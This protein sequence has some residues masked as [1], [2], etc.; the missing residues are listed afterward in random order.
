[1]QFEL[2]VAVLTDAYF[3][4]GSGNGALMYSIFGG[5]VKDLRIWLAEG[6][7][8]DGWEPKNREALGHSI[9]VSSLLFPERSGHALILSAHSKRKSPHSLLSSTSMRSRSSGLGM[10]LTSGSMKRKLYMLCAVL[11]SSRGCPSCIYNSTQS[12]CA[13]RGMLPDWL[14][15]FGNQRSFVLH[16]LVICLGRLIIGYNS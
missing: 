7:F 1:M 13:K 9:A 10:R 11:P 8:P 6:R 2:C 12:R 4:L 14:Y 5:N 16:K 15:L 3:S